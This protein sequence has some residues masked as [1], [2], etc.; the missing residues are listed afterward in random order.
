M[1]TLEIKSIEEWMAEN[2]NIPEK[3]KQIIIQGNIPDDWYDDIEE[4]E[5]EE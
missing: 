5:E 1:K 2:I 3:K 4:L